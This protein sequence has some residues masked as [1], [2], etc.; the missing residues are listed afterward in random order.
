[1]NSN[2]RGALRRTRW[3]IVAVFIT[4]VALQ[5]AV[6]AFS[7]EVLS[8]VRA[9]VNGESLYSKAQ[10]DAH[11]RLIA[12]IEYRHEDDYQAF[13]RVLAVPLG[14]RVARE[15]LQQ[16]RRDVDAARLGFAA[17]GN[18]AD[19]IDGMVRLFVWFE[20]LPFM[21]SAIA[22]WTEGDEQIAR[23]HALGQKAQRLVAAEV[24]AAA[25][26]PIRLQVRDLNERLS[27]LE[28]RFSEQLGHA[29]RQTQGLLIGANIGLALLLCA[30]GLAFVRRSA[31]MQAHTEDALR[32]R[33]E[34]LQRLLD[35]AAE[36]LYGVDV[37]GCCTFINRAALQM[38]GYAREDE[39]LGRDIHQLIHHSRAD[40]SA[41]PV[42]Q[43]E[44]FAAFRLNRRVH[45]PDTVIWRRDGTSFPAECWSHPVVEGRSTQGAVVTFVDISQRVK[46]QAALRAGELRVLQLMD[47][48]IEGVITIDAADR[49][50]FFNRAAE[51]LFGVPSSAAKRCL[52]DR[53]ITSP[54]GTVVR[55]DAV[56][57]G[58]VELRGTG[59]D[60]RAF[61]IEVSVSRLEVETG[62]LLTIVV[63]DVT[64]QHAIREE[65]RAREAHEA[66]SRAKTEFL[67]RMS[68]ELRT[69]LN[70]VLG[71]SNLLREDKR[72]PPTL[73]QLERIQHIE[74]AGAHLLALVN[75]VLDLS[76]VESGQMLVTLEP[77][78]LGHVVLESFGM[79]ASL[80]AE[81]S[82]QLLI[83]T[84]S[85]EVGPPP[86]RATAGA[87][88]LGPWVVADA[89]RLRQVIVNLLSN[90]VKYNHAGGQVTLSYR[91]DETA[92]TVRV[93][94]TGVGMAAEQL[95]RLFEPFNRLGAEKSGVEGTG[96]GL[97]L[98]R[99]LTELMGGALSLQSEI[100]H[101][102]TATLTLKLAP[103]EPVAAQQDSAHSELAPIA[104]QIDVLYVEDDP[105][106]AELVRQVLGLR[107]AVTLRVAESGSRAMALAKERA[108]DLMLI[109]MNLG[110]MTGRQL[111][112]LLRLE[113]TLRGVRLVAL[114]AD[115]LPEQIADAMAIGFERY[116]TK[117]LDFHD[118]LRLV[119]CWVRRAAGYA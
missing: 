4:I 27:A 67:S 113:P 66:A 52:I 55:F 84:G 39:L 111:A 58:V 18:H 64:E 61:P 30:T 49:V 20:K 110:D 11:E 6:T 108:P 8:A 42:G 33:E 17:G 41:L 36:G 75:D 50:V 62:P 88:H 89:V 13:E 114:S 28:V 46:M 21:A 43:S 82:V 77:V 10:K 3:L 2:N 94:D 86:D 23:M 70:A 26:A 16:P 47:V 31:R 53:F 1:M 15:A 78:A 69:P 63:R 29:S 73:Q 87:G 45:L 90:A 5:L 7:I 72:Q 100:G 95:V 79:V 48:V 117:P 115:A 96:I 105:V 119:D 92:C 98:S 81:R 76:R 97:V 14:D 34:S 83:D 106:N 56:P 65:R 118:L 51:T 107:P 103:P 44:I 102:T 80:A 32:R 57:A 24:D 109:D 35:S 40:G 22:T 54:Q 60:G 112:H 38:L 71:F 9:Y 101:G 93:A 116:L 12:Y 99:R 104:G 37:Q 85:H 91:I 68:H 25:L 74:N 19:D 59:P